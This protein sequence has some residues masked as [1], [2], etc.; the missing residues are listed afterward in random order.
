MEGNGEKCMDWICDSMN[1]HPILCFG[2]I[3]IICLAV[4]AIFGALVTSLLALVI[5]IATLIF[6]IFHA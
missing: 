4:E 1:E 2:G 6:I 5:N 3:L